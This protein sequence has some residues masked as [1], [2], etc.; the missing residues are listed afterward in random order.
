M[1]SVKNQLQK[2]FSLPKHIHLVGA[3]GVHMSAIGQILITKGHVIS[4]SDLSSSD[5]KQLASIKATD[6]RNK[7]AN[8]DEEAVRHFLPSVLSDSQLDQ[9]INILFGGIFKFLT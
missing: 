4:G 7:I 9:I 3:G 6:I 1:K 8:Q 5:L 2:N